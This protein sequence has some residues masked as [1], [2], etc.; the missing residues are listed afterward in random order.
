MT[1][2]PRSPFGIMLT[3]ICVITFSYLILP[4]LVVV[5]APLG[6]TGYLAFP[7]KGLTL[8]WYAAALEDTRY[9]GG[10]LTSLRIGA[11]VALSSTF[12]GVL[13]AYGLSRY[14][15]PGPGLDRGAASCRR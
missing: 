3:V 10:F 12:I 4:I 2:D 5:V 7:P 14:D 6:D 9:F 1:I 15:F 8:R 13:A 11:A